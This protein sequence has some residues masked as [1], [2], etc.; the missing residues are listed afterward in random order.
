[1][2]FVTS[3]TFHRRG[4]FPLLELWYKRTEAASDP[5][6]SVDDGK[7][8][9]DDTMESRDVSLSGAI[10]GQAVAAKGAP[11]MGA[12]DG[13]F[14]VLSRPSLEDVTPLSFP[15]HKQNSDL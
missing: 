3:W 13:I 15:T 9:V 12:G 10:G 4:S 8:L 14:V 7:L 2:K 1:M 5:R 6:A 11:A